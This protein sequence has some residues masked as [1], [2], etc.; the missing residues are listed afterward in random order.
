MHDDTH[1][2]ETAYLLNFNTQY[3]IKSATF[4]ALI[5]SIIMQS[6][7][8]LIVILPSVVVPF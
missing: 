7:F 4:L 3:S 8:L 2:N 5:M 6:D 1:H